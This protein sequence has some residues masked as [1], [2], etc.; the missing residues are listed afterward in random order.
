MNQEESSS[1]TRENQD[2]ARAAEPRTAGAGGKTRDVAAVNQPGVQGRVMGLRPKVIIFDFDGTVADSLWLGI[3]VMNQLSEDFGYATV[4]PD[5]VPAY[6]D[7][8]ARR[9]MKMLGIRKMALPKLLKR[10]RKEVGRRMSEVRPFE[11]ILPTLADLKDRGYELGVLTTNSEENVETFLEHNGFGDLFH[12]VTGKS[13][14]W[15]KKKDIARLLS[16]R[17]LQPSDVV[18]VGDERRDIEACKANDVP[19]VAVGWG[20]NSER[21][22]TELEP[23]YFV[24]DLQQL[25]RLFP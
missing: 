17:G 24:R 16:E 10:I 22:L 7:M 3:E 25:R 20:F 1:Q 9:I 6:R 15:G 21:A 13:S 18:Y 14:V 8:G 4:T 11:G 5:E 19:M 23:D 12:F 2:S